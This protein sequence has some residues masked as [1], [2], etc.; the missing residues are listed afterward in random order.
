M[1]TTKNP[2][3]IAIDGN[4]LSQ[5][6]FIPDKDFY[7]KSKIKRKRF[8]LIYRGEQSPTLDE[9]RALSSFFDKDFL[10][11]LKPQKS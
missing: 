7:Q 5:V 10:E 3:A 8:G 1:N 4:E 2:L 11:L 9:L 6:K